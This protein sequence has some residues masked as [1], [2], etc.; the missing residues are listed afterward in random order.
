MKYSN[1]ESIDINHGHVYANRVPYVKQAKPPHNRIEED[2]RL[3]ARGRGLKR[4]RRNA[5][6]RAR[7]PCSALG[8]SMV[9]FWN[10]KDRSLVALLSLF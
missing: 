2:H 4:L 6:D 7:G 8:S 10:S 3:G 9:Y 5:Y 1:G